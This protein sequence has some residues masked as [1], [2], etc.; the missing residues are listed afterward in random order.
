MDKKEIKNT[1]NIYD[2]TVSSSINR[3][4]LLYGTDINV[5]K[6]YGPSCVD[7]RGEETTTILNKPDEAPVKAVREK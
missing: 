1:S 3:N 4:S 7:M 5:K 6:N 2:S